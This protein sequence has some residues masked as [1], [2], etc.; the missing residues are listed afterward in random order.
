MEEDNAPER[1]ERHFRVAM[2]IFLVALVL[3]MYFGTADPTGD[4]KRLLT[5]CAAFAFA[6][7]WALAVWWNKHPV[8]R[9]ALFLELLAAFLL[10]YAVGTAHSEFR[11]FGLIELGGFFALFI[12]Y[13]IASQVYRTAAQVMRLMLVL[14]IAVALASLYGFLQKAGLDPLPWADRSSD[15][16]TNLPATFGNPN[17]AAHVL[18]LALPMACFLVVSGLAGIR[19]GGRAAWLTP[20]FALLCLAIFSAHL[21]YTGQR[22]GVIALAAAFLLLSAA[23]LI[24]RRFRNP[25]LGAACSLLLVAALGVGGLGAGMAVS[26]WRTGVALPLDSSLLVRYQS[27]VSAANMLFDRPILGHGPGAYAI[28]YSNYWTPFEKDWFAQELR[29]NNHVHNDLIEVGIDAG[30]PAAGAYLG[31]LLLGAGYS[32]LMAFT[33]VAPL[34]RRL[35]YA[36]AAAFIAFLVDGLFGFNLR[37]PVSAAMLFLLLGVLEGWSSPE[38]TRRPLRRLPWGMALVAFLFALLGARVFGAQ[39]Y[40]QQG[41]R[42]QL[43]KDYNRAAE[44]FERGARMTPWDWQFPRRLGLV[45]MAQGD[46]KSAL[47]HFTDSLALNPN[48][49]MTRLPLAHAKMQLAQRELAADPA[50]PERALKTLDDAAE[51]LRQFLE[52]CPNFTDAHELL[53]RIASMSAV[54]VARE[55]SPESI[56]R[57]EAYWRTAEAHLL[58]ATRHAVTKESEQYRM[59]AK[60]RIALNETDA[61][62]QALSQAAQADPKDVETWPLLLEFANKHK[63]FDGARN[64]LYAQIQRLKET[65][66]P[67][68]TALGTLYLCLANVLEN[69]YADGAG[70]A[71]AFQGAWES[72]PERPELW[73]NLARY[74]FEKDQADLLK[75]AVAQSC[76]KAEAGGAHPPAYVAAVNTVLQ[77]GPTALESATTVVLSHVRAHRPGQGLT[78]AQQYGWA[79]RMLLDAVKAAPSDTP[80]VCTACM[81]LGIIEAGCDDVTAA[82]LLFSRARECVD[83]AHEPFLAIHWADTL[84]RLNRAGE[85]LTLLLDAKSKHADNLDVRWALARTLVKESR[86]AEARSEYESLLQEKDMTAEGKAMLEK[87]LNAL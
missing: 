1:T 63:R 55:G 15:V 51:Q 9:P 27:Y 47:E 61:A 83:A 66:P 3:A 53:G 71:K 45:C 75:V 76:G 60:V 36:L 77:G 43:L 18:V 70:V 85:A 23:W 6:T 64:T 13:F 58:Q 21:Y 7:W 19:G 28:T 42:A 26:K 48:Y 50:T 78:A 2:A 5:Q 32:L 41:S 35:G 37:V 38:S 56:A 86:R 12:L 73:T 16:Y 72:I 8:R 25:V 74:A 87:E 22:A 54:F 69:G 24:G 20:L 4:F 17:F 82:D 49:L 29:V 59:L 67:E 40:L 65:S 81:N 52:V 14:C 62:E 46:P 68:P 80:G 84:V 79:A 57:A 33:A 39:Y 30:L 44:C 31:L 11:C 10:L 34:R